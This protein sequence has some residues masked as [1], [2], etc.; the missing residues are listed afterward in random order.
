MSSS[1][2]V[3]DEGELTGGRIFYGSAM[4]VN[5]MQYRKTEPSGKLMLSK[6]IFTQKCLNHNHALI[7]VQHSDF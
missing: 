3:K 2:V 4:S 1:V 7:M 6:N 5:E